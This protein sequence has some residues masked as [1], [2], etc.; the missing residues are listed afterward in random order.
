M[1]LV[2][3][4]RS[5]DEWV[6][7]AKAFIVNG[8]APVQRAPKPRKPKE[9]RDKSGRVIITDWARGETTLGTAGALHTDDLKVINGIGPKMEGILNSFGI[10]SWEQVGSFKK[11]DISTVTEAIDTF[12]GR[13]ERDEWV[14]Q[15]KDLVKRFPLTS[16]YHRPT[17]D[18]YLNNSDDENPWE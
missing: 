3:R 18:T 17:R 6:D 7:Q 1:A 15:A 5:C 12:P 2:P 11:S 8:H 4:W 10:T 13:I 14:S 9:R 16:P